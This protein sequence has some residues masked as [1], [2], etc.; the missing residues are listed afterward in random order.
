MEGRRTRPF[1]HNRRRELGEGLFLAF[2]IPGKYGPPPEIVEAMLVCELGF[3]PDVLDKLPYQLI[4][5]M[6]IY[7]GV[8][9]V[10]EWGGEWQP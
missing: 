7:K 10:A 3:T 1:S 8:R 5:K 2:K 4:Q 6:M 9:H